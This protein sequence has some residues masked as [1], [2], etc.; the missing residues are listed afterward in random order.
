MRLLVYTLLR[1]V[2]VL[3]SGA[4]L[5]L[6]GLRGALLFAGAVIM[7]ALVSYLGLSGPRLRAA[8]SLRDV[9]ERSPRPSRPDADSRAEDAD[10]DDHAYTDDDAD[11]DGHADSEAAQPPAP[12]DGIA[13]SEPLDD[14]DQHR[15]RSASPQSRDREPAAGEVSAEPEQERDRQASHEL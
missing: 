7:G 1:L 9:A 5:Y 6:L 8:Q 4:V 13:T 11:I 3:A 10:I 12:S 15:Y 14:G 2:I